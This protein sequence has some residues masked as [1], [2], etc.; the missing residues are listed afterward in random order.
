MLGCPGLCKHWI[1]ERKNE[2][3]TTENKNTK[4]WKTEKVENGSKRE[5]MYK[6]YK[7]FF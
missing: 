7:F 5:V 1:Q 3:M 4:W 2:K 6:V